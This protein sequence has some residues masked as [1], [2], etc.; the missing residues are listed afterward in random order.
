[1]T[2]QEWIVKG[3]TGLSSK[4]IWSY[5]MLNCEPDFAYA[6]SDPSDFLRC[7]WLLN[8]AP[9]WVP[10]L[11]ELAVV[12]PSSPWKALAE[13]WGEL[14]EMLEAVWP[15]SCASGKYEDEPHAEAM[16]ARMK[17]LGC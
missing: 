7:Y 8:L 4:T 16:Y 6:P 14:T 13:H 1:M 10:R 3:K 11:G 15:K 12:Y 9:E 17:E 5:F 2:I